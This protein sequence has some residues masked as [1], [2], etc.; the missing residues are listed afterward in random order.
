MRPG[1][2]AILLAAIASGVLGQTADELIAKN[3]AARGGLER[4]H[5]VRSIRMTG[6]LS[7]GEA[8]MPSVLEIKRPNQT[9]W[10]FTVNGQTV[11]QAY[12]GKNGWAV[13]PFAAKN[14]PG[15]LSADD[16]KDLEL[17]ADM[18]GPLVDHGAKGNKVEVMGLETIGDRSGWRIHA[19]L[20]NGDERDLYLDAKTHLQFLTVTRRTIDGKARR[21]ETEIGD[22]REVGGL[23]LPYSFVT[24]A[25]GSKETQALTLN[26]IELNVPIDDARFAM[27]AAEAAPRTPG[28]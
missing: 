4:M 3:V 23:M 8:R 21:I 22:Y 14:A 25:A 9:R 7:V 5:S 10:E 18:D 6:T 16:L 28:N 13:M 24:R 17:Q 20:R 2:T 15:Q 27:P 26:K 1:L 12:D 19:V 11:I